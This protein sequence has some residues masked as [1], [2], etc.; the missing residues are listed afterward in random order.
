MSLLVGL[1][2]LASGALAQTYTDVGPKGDDHFSAK[3]ATMTSA[4]TPSAEPVKDTGQ[5]LSV[6]LQGTT[7]PITATVI[8]ALANG[9]EV[10]RVTVLATS[11]TSLRYNIPAPLDFQNVKVS[12][13]TIGTDTLK[14]NIVQGDRD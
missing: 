4:T 12:A 8:F 6:I 3:R 10:S 14:V 7:A 5:N 9:D 1:V 13:T 11:S 2:L